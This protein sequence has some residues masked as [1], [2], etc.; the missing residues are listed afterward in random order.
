MSPVVIPESAAAA[1]D[2]APL[3][4]CPVKIL[5][6]MPDIL[7]TSFNHRAMVHGATGL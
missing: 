5:T 4:E 6:S 3:V 2:E 7:G 1:E